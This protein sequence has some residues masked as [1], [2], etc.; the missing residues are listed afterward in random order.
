VLCADVAVGEPSGLVNRKL[1]D[2]LGPWGK[3]DLPEH[4]AVTAPDDELNCGANL[5]ELY[6]KVGQD[7]GGDAIALAN[8]PQKDVLCADVIVVEAMS[9]F[10][11][12]S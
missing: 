9:F 2:F 12:K 4:G 8:Q 1:D 3:S 11:G 6:A 7:L 10:L 5:I